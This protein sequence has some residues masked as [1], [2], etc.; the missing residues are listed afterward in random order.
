M[1][2]IPSGIRINMKFESS[3]PEAS[4]SLILANAQTIAISAFAQYEQQIE[5]LSAEVEKL[6]KEKKALE[7]KLKGPEEEPVKDPGPQGP[8][9]SPQQINNDS[10]E[11]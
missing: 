10:T 8:A 2:Y 11:V 4:F 9:T 5:A 3:Q 7:D 1:I 6:R